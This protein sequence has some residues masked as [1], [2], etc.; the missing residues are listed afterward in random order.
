M[1]TWSSQHCHGIR[2]GKLSALCPEKTS[3]IYF[4]VPKPIPTT[5]THKRTPPQNGDCVHVSQKKYARKL[6]ER[7]EM[8]NAKLVITPMV[9]SPTL[10]SFPLVDGTKYRKVVGAKYKSLANATSELTWFHSLLDEVG[11]TLNGI[12]VIWCDNSNT[13]SLAIKPM[14]HACVK[15][16]P[17]ND[18]VVDVLTKPL[19]IGVFAQFH[20]R[21]N[22]VAFEVF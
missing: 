6:L 5:P 13:I 18:Q 1:L 3:L 4:L 10:T 17:G 8:A 21:L 12:P 19:T 16:V 15:H 14:L 11:V 2:A 20:D 22:V 9:S 7:A